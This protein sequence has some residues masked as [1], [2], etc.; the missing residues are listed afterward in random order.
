MVNQIRAQFERILKNIEW[1]DE[2][3]RVVALK[4]LKNMDSHIGYPE[5]LLNE[6]KIEEYMA[7]LLDVDTDSF[8]EAS[9]KIIKNRMLKNNAELRKPVNKIDWTEIANS[10]FI[11]AHYYANKNSIRKYNYKLFIKF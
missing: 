1:M 3:T 9:F 8:Y 11:N 7:D 5:E 2:K 10:A 6:Q 4:K